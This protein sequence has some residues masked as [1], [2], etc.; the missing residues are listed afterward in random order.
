MQ[1]KD[2]EAELKE[3]D[4]GL[5][6]VPNPNREGLS[7]IKLNGVDICPVPGDEI[8]EESDPNYYYVFPNGMAAR[9][10][11]RKEALSYVHSVLDLV[12]TEQGKEE[13]YG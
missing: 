9:H 4:P 1:I 2:F 8:K 3:L 5:S 11:S 12:K 6:I 7:N 10:K 13:F